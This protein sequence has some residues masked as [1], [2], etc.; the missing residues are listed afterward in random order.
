[1]VAAVVKM[2]SVS[3]PKTP[4]GRPRRG[5]RYAGI[6]LLL[7][8]FLAGGVWGVHRLGW[9]GRFSGKPKMNLLLITLDTTRADHLGCF[10]GTA[11]ATPNLDQ[12]AQGGVRC[13]QCIT[14]CPLTLPAHA[15]IMTGLNS[16][17]H[18]ARCN[19][20]NCVSAG[21]LTLAE[22]LQAAGCR[23]RAAVASFVLN[24]QFG[25][26]QGFEVYHDVVP[27]AEGAALE[28]ERRADAV[29]DDAVSLLQSVGRE[30]FFLWVHFYD[31]HRPYLSAEHPDR[32]SPEAY[33][34]EVSF[35]DKHIGRLLQEL[36][37]LKLDSNTLVV[38]VGDH[39][40]GLGQHDEPTHGNFLYETTLHV[41]LIF[42]C[43]G[44][45]DSGRVVNAQ[46][47]VTDIAPTVLALLGCPEMPDLQGTSIVP[48]LRGQELPVS[49]PAY[50][51][52]FEA[53]VVFGL[54]PL[55]S[56][57]LD[58]W[59]FILAPEPELYNL[60]VDPNENDNLA[61]VEAERSTELRG[62][63]RAL[64][65]EAPAMVQPDPRGG[66]AIEDVQRLRSLGYVGAAASMPADLQ[67]ELNQFEPRGGNPRSYSKL[68][69]S[70]M[71]A[72]DSIKHG[73][74]QAAER[75]LRQVIEAL[76]SASQ[77]YAALAE[78]LGGQN[79]LAEAI[80]AAK[81][82]VSRAP[83]NITIRS[84]YGSLLSDAGRWADAEA[85][86]RTVL[87]QAPRDMMVLHNMGVT[88]AFLGRLDEAEQHFQIGLSIQ[89]N[90]PR[91]LQ[92][93]GVLRN[94]QGRRAESIAYLRKALAID[95]N[96]QQAAQDLR[97]LEGTP[98]Q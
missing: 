27:P 41:P 76:P 86:L 45:L 50:A 30:R 48:L 54:S 35:M 10:G 73:Q 18:G 2:R 24:R 31:P 15:S 57:R 44:I 74:F 47:R 90:N 84:T 34:D 25:L 16:F 23:T 87:R 4:P 62:K 52:T 72:Q 9:L 53:N 14:S 97:A 63:L 3:A 64:V 42:R 39:G 49:L 80:D 33:A 85:Q 7:A 51:E 32:T 56:L 59:K 81:E 37:R 70:F 29:C 40:E 26:D 12:L 94:R 6:V 17:V 68:I 65:A 28:A 67:A 96:F 8:G 55:R 79:R 5:F 46:V 13:A 92:A 38:A 1:L 95:P 77:P 93:M 60:A 98:R 88:L 11:A 66:L 75:R 19:G 82:A 36:Q 78:A 89:P 91:L 69:R 61:S 21:N 22:V 43:P 83:D 71:Q 58:G 20:T